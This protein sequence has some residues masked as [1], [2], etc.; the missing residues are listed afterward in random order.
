M[1]PSV[2]AVSVSTATTPVGVVALDILANLDPSASRT[3]RESL[4]WLN[5][6]FSG[7]G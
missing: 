1:Y 6:Q 5:D 2:G 7:S 3:N 4:I